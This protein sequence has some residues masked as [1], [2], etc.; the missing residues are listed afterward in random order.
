M[1]LLNFIWLTLGVLVFT[2]ILDVVTFKSAT[3]PE[4]LS[5]CMWELG[6]AYLGF[7]AGHFVEKYD[8]IRYMSAKK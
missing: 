7:F 5:M 3:F 6:F 8:L 4:F 2:A 1:K